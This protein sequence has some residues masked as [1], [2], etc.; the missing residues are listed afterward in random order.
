MLG[1][2]MSANRQKR[3][4]NA[5][6]MTTVLDVFS[7]SFVVFDALKFSFIHLTNTYFLS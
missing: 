3:G 4:E 1:V 2:P 5:K 7:S 6:A